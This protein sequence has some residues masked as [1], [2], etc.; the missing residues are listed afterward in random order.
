MRGRR[1]ARPV[2]ARITGSGPGR[3][4]ELRR[5]DFEALRGLLPRL[6]GRRAVLVTGGGEEAPAL[7]V[8]LAGVAAA[9]GL[10][11]ALVECDLARPRLAA[12]L[13]L[14]PSP[15]LHEHLRGAAAPPELLQPLVAAG[16]AAGAAEPLVCVAAGQPAA[17]P[18]T[19]LA[20]PA[21]GGAAARLREAYELVVLAGPPLAD[22]AGP[23]LAAAAAEGTLVALAADAGRRERRAARA[24]A[25]ELPA[26]LLGFVLVGAAQRS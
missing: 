2:L 7:A 10:R 20:A 22:G 15:G 4:R 9:V 1:G 26:P 16:S 23:A 6:G 13:G 14:A 24:A 12:E 17:D 19:L 25:A 8:A 11:A 21:F 5:A 18:A 3:R